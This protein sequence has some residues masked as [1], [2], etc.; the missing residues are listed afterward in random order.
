LLR[1]SRA[2]WIAHASDPF[3][4][5]PLT[6]GFTARFPRRDPLSAST[7][8]HIALAAFI[9]WVGLGADGLSSD[10]LVELAE[11]VQKEFTNCV[12]FTSKL[13]FRNEN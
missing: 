7:R 6:F 8:Q 4:V 10:E 11:E 3:A 9:A 12:F 5:N 2:V 13:V 1:C